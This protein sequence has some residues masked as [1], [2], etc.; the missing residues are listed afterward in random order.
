MLCACWDGGYQDGYSR[1]DLGLS[2]KLFKI[3][4][5]IAYC[6][7]GL[8]NERLKRF[9]HDRGDGGHPGWNFATGTN[10][11]DQCFGVLSDFLDHAAWQC[12]YQSGYVSLKCWARFEGCDEALKLIED[13]GLLR[14]LR[15]ARSLDELG[16]RVVVP[17][18]CQC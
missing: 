4:L 8:R 6:L 15:L 11:I 10:L 18:R 9:N 17:R 13:F 3:T 7:D 16:T 1:S 12:G 5:D 2:D 14:E